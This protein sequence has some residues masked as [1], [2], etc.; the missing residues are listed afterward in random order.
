MEKQ[1]NKLILLEIWIDVVIHKC[2][3][4]LKSEKKT[5]LDF[6]KG[7]VKMS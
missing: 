7:K 1:Y 6:S 2:L 3:S 4:L 5:V